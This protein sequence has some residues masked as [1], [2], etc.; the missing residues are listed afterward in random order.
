MNDTN[1]FHLNCIVPLQQEGPDKITVFDLIHRTTG[2]VEAYNGVLNALIP[3][4]SN[5]FQFITKLQSNEQKK[6]FDANLLAASGG[7]SAE[8][9]KLKIK[10]SETP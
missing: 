5:F 1:H 10:V 9:Q 3:T 6:A 8:A 4:K 2:S 7:E